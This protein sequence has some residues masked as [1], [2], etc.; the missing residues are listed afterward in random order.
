MLQDANPTGTGELT[1]VKRALVEIRQLRA[2]LEQSKRSR[3]EPIAILGMAM[4]LPG[5]VTTPQ[6]FWEA[7]A[8]GEN[9]IAPIPAERWEANEY[10]D[11][12]P[13]HPGTM[14]DRHGGFL[15]GI[16]EFDAEFF[17][18][19]PRE[20][21]SMDPQQRLLLELTWEAL[22]RAAIDPKTLAGAPAGV[23]LG[24][25]N[26]DYARFSMSD[27]REIDAYASVGSA[28][29]IAAGRISYFL[30]ARGPALVIDTACSASLVA[31]HLA[32]E[33]LRRGETNLAIV[34][35]ANL[36]LSPEFNVS[37]SKTRMLSRDGLCKT[38]D[39]AA[40]G[41]VRSEGCAVV[42]LK[43]LSDALRDG[44][45]VL[46]SV[47]GSAINQDGRSA[48]LTAPNGP[49]QE[50]VIR[51]ALENADLAPALVSYVEAHG[52]GTPLGD[53]MEVRALGAVYGAGRSA[54]QPLRIGSVK[55]NLGHTEAAAGLAGL[56]KVV[57]MMQPGHG[58]APHLH[59]KDPNPKIDWTGWPVEV[60]TSLVPWPPGNQTLYAGVSSFGFSGTNA[61]VLLASAANVAI[62]SVP[63]AKEPESVPE[64]VLV[65]SA[66]H[67]AALRELAERYVVFLRQTGERFADICFTAAVARANFEHRLALRARNSEEAAAMLERWLAG[68]P[69]SG[70]ATSDAEISPPSEVGGDTIARLQREYL[71]GSPLR[72]QDLNPEGT[73]RRVELP[74]YPFRRTPF[75]LGAPPQAKREQERE[76]RWRGALQEAERQSRQGPLD[77]QPG[78]Y[79]EKW[80]ALE[81]LTLA[82]ARNLL[83]SAGA[84]AQPQAVSVDEVLL[85]CGFQPLYRNLVGRWL[86]GL[87]AAQLLVEEGGRFRA[88][89][90]FAPVPLDR[91]WRRAE[92]LLEDD[93]GLLVYLRQCGS[94][95]EDVLTGRTS[96]L[97]TLFPEGSFAL[98][99][100]LY[101]TS[102]GAR[103]LNPIVA[104]AV[105]SAVREIGRQRNARILE[106]GG[107]TGGTASA[108][109]PLLQSGRAEYWF[110]DVSELFLARARSRFSAYPFMHYAIF[111]LD[112]PLDEQGF[113]PGQFDVILGANVVHASRN[114]AAALA[115]L[116]RLLAPG[117]MLALLESTCHHGWFDMT[118]GLIEGWQHFA[119]EERKEHPLLNPQQWRSVLERN[120][121]SEA[122]A[123]P[124]QDSP[125]SALGQHVLLARRSDG[126]SS[127]VH[128]EVSRRLPEWKAHDN[129]LPPA[130]VEADLAGRLRALPAAQRE[131]AIEEFVRETIRRVFNLARPAHELGARDRLTDLGMDSLIALELRSALAKGLGLGARISSTIAF[132]TG[133]V[134]E[135][136]HVLLLL[137]DSTGP[138]PQSEPHSKPQSKSHSQSQT[139][140]GAARGLKIPASKPAPVTAQ[141]LSEMSEE[142]VE[143][144]LNQRLSRR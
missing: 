120:G 55:T 10:L 119:D 38:F 95:L 8:G 80:E 99:E 94:L 124:Q 83:A 23:Y 128:V 64:S 22:E 6:R 63:T 3:R 68:D 122:A 19:N 81:R 79:R 13:D 137:L 11:A 138:E 70:L 57:M 35:G 78:R 100:G 131:Q 113:P 74:V 14:Y 43:R 143:Q 34:G 92:D 69:V 41:Y 71:R 103:Y 82:H 125:A 126:K 118:T 123:F 62:D 86:R 25:S 67:G 135:L 2:E 31:L 45:R 96:A 117:G 40:D 61:H 107:G 111:D 33:S 37:F 26:S 5:G 76:Q 12:D 129:G 88:S 48:G 54:A 28:L 130:L 44:D 20:A 109:L 32:V 53:P 72:W 51:A 7:L 30:G 27:A 90:A 66:A 115:S 139:G 134:G 105:S 18:I 65:F 101:E 52:T 112:R 50:A 16:D 98:A 110:T 132:D 58:I 97:E 9:L 59:L 142:E 133:T 141:Q 77:W 75:W 39:A 15:T 46:A 49:A 56:M 29:S 42:V 116:H 21:A 1:P 106:V 84:F 36:I 87:A 127:Q 85:Q 91:E 4:R 136:A 104:V 73:H 60:P 89:A 121:F 140:N 47:V 93:P 108:V 102:P 144:L 17:G 24:L 114:L